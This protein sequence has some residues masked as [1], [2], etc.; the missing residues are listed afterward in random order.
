VETAPAALYATALPERVGDKVKCLR[1]VSC[2]QPNPRS[3]AWA[4]ALLP[5][6]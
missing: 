5:A 6:W 1:G 4:P 3:V 2:K